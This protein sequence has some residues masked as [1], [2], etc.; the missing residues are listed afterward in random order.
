MPLPGSAT[1]LTSRTAEIDAL[2]AEYN[3]K[4]GWPAQGCACDLAPAAREG[5]IR[6]PRGMGLGI[7]ALMLTP[8]AGLV[9]HRVTRRRRRRRAG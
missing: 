6:P 8:L 2:L 9:G 1:L 7:V 3:A 5:F 4:H